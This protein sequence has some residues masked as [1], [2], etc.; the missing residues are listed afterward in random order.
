MKGFCSIVDQKPILFR[1]AW[2]NWSLEK[3]SPTKIA[4][5]WPTGKRVSAFLPQR[6]LTGFYKL[7][8]QNRSLL[9]YILE[10]QKIKQ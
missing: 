10:P 2:Y 8:D 1:D 6:G 3:A 5:N 4:R 7:K 9:V